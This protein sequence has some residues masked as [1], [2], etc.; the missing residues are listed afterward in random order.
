MR[1]LSA[2]CLAVLGGKANPSA[3]DVKKILTSAG[4]EI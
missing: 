3:D 2:Y 1:Y 4:V